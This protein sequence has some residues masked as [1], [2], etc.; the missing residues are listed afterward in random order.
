MGGS[1]Y[2]NWQSIA[3]ETAAVL[4]R[5]IAEPRACACL[6][7]ALLSERRRKLCIAWIQLM[8][9]SCR[10]ACQKF[11]HLPRS[12]SKALMGKEVGT[13]F[14]KPASDFLTLSII[15]IDCKTNQNQKIF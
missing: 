11:R 13:A 15:M 2:N 14:W 5:R 10:R 8:M 12:L 9:L 1:L 7:R 4:H 3:R 6:G